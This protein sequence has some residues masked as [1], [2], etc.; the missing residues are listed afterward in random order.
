[1][2]SLRAEQRL[3]G[4]WPS[5][6]AATRARRHR[7]PGSV[8]GRASRKETSFSGRTTQGSFAAASPRAFNFCTSPCIH[9]PL[10]GRRLYPERFNTGAHLC[11]DWWLE[12]QWQL[13]P[14]FLPGKSHGRGSLVGC[15]PWIAKSRTGLKRLSSSSRWQKIRACC[16]MFSDSG[17]FL[18]KRANSGTTGKA[19]TIRTEIYSILRPSSGKEDLGTRPGLKGA[20]GE[21]E[22]YFIQY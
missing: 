8:W 21:R 20:P 3:A 12:I 10:P 15:S 14:V 22:N 11:C 13:T 18:G 19:S 6:G 7:G 2:Q 4:W 17:L 5:A 16:G 1:M 9:P